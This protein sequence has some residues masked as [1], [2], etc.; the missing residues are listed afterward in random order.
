VAI[1]Y[2]NHNPFFTH[3][4][5]GMCWLTKPGAC[6]C[7]PARSPRR[8]EEVAAVEALADIKLAH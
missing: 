3:E 1:G 8:L 5:S 2:Q 6:L 4:V 7:L